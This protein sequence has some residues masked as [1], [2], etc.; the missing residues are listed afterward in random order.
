[1]EPSL[2]LLLG[3]LIPFWLALLVVIV[4]R[5]WRS[6]AKNK[7]LDAEEVFKES[8]PSFLTEMKPRIPK[9]SIGML[10]KLRNRFMRSNLES[11][12]EG[13]Y[14]L[15]EQVPLRMD[16][17]EDNIRSLKKVW[18]YTFLLF[19]AACLVNGLYYGAKFIED[20]TSGSITIFFL[21]QYSYVAALFILMVIAALITSSFKTGLY[22]INN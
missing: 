7:A 4:N 14:E 18:G 20:S 5:P 11:I 10:S 12:D 8:K 17:D 9:P 2:I 16:D 6:S 1:M 19:A 22:L 15:S 21:V 13:D 3:G